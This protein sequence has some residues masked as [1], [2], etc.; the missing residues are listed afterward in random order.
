MIKLL[1]SDFLV[2]RLNKKTSAPVITNSVKLQKKTVFAALNVFILSKSL[3][4]FIRS[5]QLLKALAK[6]AILNFYT[7]NLFINNLLTKLLVNSNKIK[8]KI[9]IHNSFIALQ[10]KKFKKLRV[11]SVILDLIFLKTLYKFPSNDVYLIQTINSI[12]E[13]THYGAYKIFNNLTELKKILF[14]ILLI[15]NVLSKPKH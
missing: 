5:L 11:L 8:I 6:F 1:S 4:Q 10:P 14:F 13:K 3:K 9:S 7:K 15:K 2:V 12:N